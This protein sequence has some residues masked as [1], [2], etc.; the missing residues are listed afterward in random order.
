MKNKQRTSTSITDGEN[1]D[2]V[3]VSVDGSHEEQ[4]NCKAVIFLSTKK[5][6]TVDLTATS[7][8]Y[9]NSVCTDDDEEYYLPT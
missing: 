7:S 8:S 5:N 3:S 4:V 1:C 6:T 2:L 9:H